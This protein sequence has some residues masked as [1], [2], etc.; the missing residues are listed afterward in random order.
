[1]HPIFG[2]NVNIFL[3]F[4]FEQPKGM[5]SGDTINS[6]SVVRAPQIPIGDLTHK[7]MNYKTNILYNEDNMA[8]ISSVL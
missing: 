1:V 6:V 8:L 5:R 7:Y 2:L 4:R 3:P